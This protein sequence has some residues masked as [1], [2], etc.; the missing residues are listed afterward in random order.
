MSMQNSNSSSEFEH[1]SGES[2][3]RIVRP[4]Q[5]SRLA[6]FASA[7]TN[8]NTFLFGLLLIA[9]GTVL[10]SWESDVNS[11]V[12][13]AQQLTLSSATYL[14]VAAQAIE[15]STNSTAS[16]GDALHSSAKTMLTS[17]EFL[18]GLT[19]REAEYAALLTQIQKL[20][21]SA[22]SWSGDSRA[23]LGSLKDA[24]A[25]SKQ[26]AT[27]VANVLEGVRVAMWSFHTYTKSMVLDG[28]KVVKLDDELKNTIRLLNE[29]GGWIGDHGPKLIKSSMDGLEEIQAT[30]KVLNKQLDHFR[31]KDLPL[32]ARQGREARVALV[33][34]AE[35]SAAAGSSIRNIQQS[36]LPVTL[37]QLRQDAQ[38]LKEMADPVGSAG[39]LYG[40]V[41]KL[42][43]LTGV[44]ATALATLSWFA[45]HL[46]KGA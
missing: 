4:S 13:R 36:K 26:V 9:L 20:T 17:S 34:A 1:K 12:V 18:D 19:S 8:F 10:L 35:V 25:T 45:K 31:E 14:E 28:N 5:L 39:R 11:S 37:T 43:L 3:R 7:R 29:T 16:I 44:F 42:L 33:K 46:S 38:R 30:S 41:G 23:S 15:E 40:V 21:E 2:S 22:G 32:L 6:I 27:K 24:P